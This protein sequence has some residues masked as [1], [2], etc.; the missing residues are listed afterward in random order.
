MLPSV[1][2]LLSAVETVTV[3]TLGSEELEIRTPSITCCVTDAD[4]HTNGPLF[5]TGMP[6]IKE[7]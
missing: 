1:F 3:A 5:Y 2:F 4:G 7:I 6:I